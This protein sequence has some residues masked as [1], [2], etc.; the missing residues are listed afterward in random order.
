M[1]ANLPGALKRADFDNKASKFDSVMKRIGTGASTARDIID[2]IKPKVNF[3]GSRD[4]DESHINPG[5]G[6][7]YKERQIRYRK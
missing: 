5:T 7:I 1:K 4:Y 6:E 2:V 3:G